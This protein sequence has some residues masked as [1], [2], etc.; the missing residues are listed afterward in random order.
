M[1]MGS[2]D[3]MAQISPRDLEDKRER[4]GEKGADGGCVGEVRGDTGDGLQYGPVALWGNS[5]QP[6]TKEG[7]LC[8]ASFRKLFCFLINCALIKIKGRGEGN[9]KCESNDSSSPRPLCLD[10]SQGQ[11]FYSSRMGNTP[12]FM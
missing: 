7:L 2:N 4:K 10:E 8:G 5:I 1:G 3:T 11:V 6:L 12:Q 9:A